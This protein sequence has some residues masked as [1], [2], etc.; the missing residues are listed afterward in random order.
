V[1]AGHLLEHDAGLQ[2]PPLGLQV[3]LWLMRPKKSSSG[4]TS[5]VHPVWWLAPS[6]APL[7]PWKYS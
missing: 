5:P 3:V 6:P 2:A 1:L 7:S 4:A